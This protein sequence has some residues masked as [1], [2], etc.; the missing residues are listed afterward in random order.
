GNQGVNW[1]LSVANTSCS[2][3]CG[4]LKGTLTSAVYTPPSTIPLNQTATITARS[5]ADNSQIF[6]FNFLIVP[7][8]SVS[9]TNKFSSQTAG[10]PVADISATITNDVTNAGLSWT[11]TAGAA[12]C[13]P[14][15]GTLTVDAPPAL[16]AHYTPPAIPPSGP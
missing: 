14:V 5:I 4:T 8:V 10:G 6:A 3:A 13:S 9:I 7:P 1:N 16:T 2:P 12:S 11:L 15:C